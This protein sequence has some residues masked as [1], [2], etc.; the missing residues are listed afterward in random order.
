[1][2][3]PSVVLTDLWGI[4]SPVERTTLGVSRTTWRVAQGFWLTRCGNERGEAFRRECSL[5]QALAETAK[6]DPGLLLIVPSLIPTRSGDVVSMHSGFLWRLTRHIDGL[7]PSPNDPATYDLMLNVMLRLHQAFDSTANQCPT[8]P[9]IVGRVRDRLS[10]LPDTISRSSFTPKERDILQE[11]AHWLK[12]RLDRL[13]I[14]PTR[15]VHG[16]WTPLNV[17]IRRDGWAGILDFEACGCGPAVLDFANMCS[18]L[19]MWSRLDNIS[20]RIAALVSSFEEKTGVPIGLDIV[21]I[22]MLTH[23]FGHYFDWRERESTD[24]NTEV[25]RRLLG[26]IETVLRFAAK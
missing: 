3:L 18:T 25:A 23:W 16:D 24:E 12:P 9:D 6:A 2:H 11:A 22:A 17:L 13:F 19:L 7:H 8:G 21:H 20:E 14:L 1:M 5:L 15:V 10:Q 4:H 26:R